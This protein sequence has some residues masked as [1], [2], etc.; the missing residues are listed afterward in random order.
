MSSNSVD[1]MVSW[2]GWASP[3]NNGWGVWVL[4]PRTAHGQS[5]NN[6]YYISRHC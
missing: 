5:V 4:A 6:V 3:P 2:R 1:E